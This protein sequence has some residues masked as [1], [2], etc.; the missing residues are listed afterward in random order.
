MSHQKESPKIVRSDAAVPCGAIATAAK[1]RPEVILRLFL[2]VRR[3]RQKARRFH[4]RDQGTIASSF[5]YR[6]LAAHRKQAVL[7]YFREPVTTPHDWVG[8]RSGRQSLDAP[9]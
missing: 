7:S 3:Y 6:H 9:S 4:H 5:Q 2:P 8:R 1:G